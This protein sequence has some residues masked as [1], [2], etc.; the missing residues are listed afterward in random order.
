[1][2]GR[3]RRAPGEVRDAIIEVLGRYPRGATIHE[4]HAGV[5]ERL[6]G[7]V[8]PSSVRSYLQLG[9][10]AGCPGAFERVSRGR[11]KLVRPKR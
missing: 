5:E 11:Y 10:R 4:V 8:A 7:Q 9:T 1:M 6:G 3:R 2:E